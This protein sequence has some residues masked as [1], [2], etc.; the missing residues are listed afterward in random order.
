MAKPYKALREKMSPPA[1]ARA[2]ALS[3]GMLAEMPLHELRQA[4][5]LSQEQLAEI[6]GQRQASV[7]KLERRTDMYISTLRR[8]IEAM[9]GELHI[10]ARFPEG[11]VR[12]K[13][14]G[15]LDAP[16]AAETVTAS[17]HKRRSTP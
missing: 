2:E 10:L 14:L 16:Q 6:L 17:A 12:V 11:E 8:F 3:R 7:S 1:R 9:G 4:R 5:Q 15:D 13:N